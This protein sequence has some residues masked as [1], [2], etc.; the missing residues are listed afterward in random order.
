MRTLGSGEGEREVNGGIM[1]TLG[2][3]E[4]GVEG[5]EWRFIGVPTC[6]VIYTKPYSSN[7]ETHSFVSLNVFVFKAQRTTA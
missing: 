5:G 6:L 4:G 3:G 2:S 1:R 7:S